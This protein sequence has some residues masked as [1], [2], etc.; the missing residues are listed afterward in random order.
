M[1][2]IIALLF[3]T[4]FVL[5]SCSGD[6]EVGPQGPEGPPGP[7][8]PLA[9]VFDVEVDF[10]AAN[11]YEAVIDFNDMDVEVFE[12]DV[13]LVY[14]KVGEDGTAGGAPVEVFRMLP[15]TY[16]INGEQLQYNYDYTFFDI[17]LFLDGTVD[18][19]T[20]D[21]GL[22]NDRIFRIAIV[23]GEF[24]SNLDVNNMDAV[25]DALNINEQ[26]IETSNF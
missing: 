24:A 9:T 21:P 16:Y 3:C 2:R 15:Q 11:N 18:F 12:S 14:L 26:Q 5:S 20:L 19:A 22:K 7:P 6:G 17:L 10:T 25:L 8:G 23:P 1:K 4:V 13:V